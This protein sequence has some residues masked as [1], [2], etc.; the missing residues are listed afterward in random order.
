M[1]EP[2]DAA[3]S[4]GRWNV[5]SVTDCGESRVDQAQQRLNRIFKISEIYSLSRGDMAHVGYG[6]SRFASLCGAT[7]RQQIC[8]VHLNWNNLRQE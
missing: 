2:S 5:A 3:S 6:V 4:T 1:S 8:I 7:S